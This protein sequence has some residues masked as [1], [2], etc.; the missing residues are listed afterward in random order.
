MRIDERIEGEVAVL[1]I[2]DSRLDE[3]GAPDLKN[4]IAGLV[5]P[6]GTL[7]AVAFRK[8][9]DEP[10][11]EGPPFALTRAQVTG[12]AADGLGLV[13]IEAL[14]GE[15]WRAEFRRSAEPPRH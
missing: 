9:G 5:A 15:R 10:A 12:L 7:L 13:E 11:T 2:K 1:T 8:D 6:E 14:P 3:R 4:A